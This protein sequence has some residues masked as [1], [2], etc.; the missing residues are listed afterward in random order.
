VKNKLVH[1]S[2][3]YERSVV[4]QAHFIHS[5]SKK[6]RREEEILLADRFDQLTMSSKKPTSRSVNNRRKSKKTPTSYSTISGNG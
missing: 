1:C 6:L 4:F 3:V 5:A 2:I